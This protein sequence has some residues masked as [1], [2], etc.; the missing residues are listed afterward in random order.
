MEEVTRDG[1]MLYLT[2]QKPLALGAIAWEEGWDAARW[3]RRLDTLVFLWP[4]DEHG[5]RGY[6]KAHGE[7][8]DRQAAGGGPAPVLLRVPFADALAANPSLMPLFCRYNSG[9]PRAQ[10]SGGSPRG[11]ST[12][13]PANECDFTPGRVQELA[14][15]RGP[16]ALPTSTAVRSESDWEPLFG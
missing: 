11:D 4:G 1:R 8:Y 5:P 15:D 13:R 14:F 10:P 2:D 3:L 6:A 9:G 7:K 12:F 16:V